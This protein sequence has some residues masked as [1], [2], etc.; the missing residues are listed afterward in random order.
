MLKR[1]W[2]FWLGNQQIKAGPV[3]LLAQ[4]ADVRKQT[5]MG[6]YTPYDGELLEPLNKVISSNKSSGMIVLHTMGSHYP[7]QNRYPEEFEQFKPATKKNR[8][9][10]L[11]QKHRETILN[12]YDNSILYTDFFLSELISTLNKQKGRQYCFMCQIM[13][14]IFSRMLPLVL[15]GA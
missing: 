9:I 15:A 14:K 13:A 4:Q 11:K 8:H 12:N 2:D 10:P 7:F 6:K 3:D 1:V 5:A